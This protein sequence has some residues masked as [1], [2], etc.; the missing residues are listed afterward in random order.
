MLKPQGYTDLNM[1]RGFTLIE[2]SVVLVIIGVLI[3]GI[4][5]GQSMVSSVKGQKLVS[6][7]GQYE[8]AFKTFKTVYEFFPGDSKAFLPQ[9][10]EDDVLYFGGGCNGIYAKVESFQSWSH[11]SQAKML[12]TTYIGY[13]PGW[14]SGPHNNDIADSSLN[15]VT[16]PFVEISGKNAKSKGY[17]KVPILSYL[18]PGDPLLFRLGDIDPET[19]LLLETKLNYTNGSTR[20]INNFNGKGQCAS[21]ITPNIVPCTSSQALNGGVYFQ[22]PR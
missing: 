19:V 10:D 20:G 13:R 8:T 4:L 12:D 18:N 7:L 9:G 21:V 11:L 1:K 6:Q 14:C 15:G 3:G 22:I 16:H 5:V 17:N 2:L